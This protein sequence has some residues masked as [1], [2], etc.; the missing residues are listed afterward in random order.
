[1][2]KNY[3]LNGIKTFLIILCTSLITQNFAFAQNKGIV[4]GKLLDAS[5]KE[6]LFFANIS[7]EGTSIGTS[8]DEEG[9]FL[10]NNVPTGDQTL[11]ISYI[12]YK[13]LEVQVSI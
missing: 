2:N 4:T 10:L 3:L 1:M 9:E 6:P 8:S 5:T 12:G 11:I 7:I 13:S